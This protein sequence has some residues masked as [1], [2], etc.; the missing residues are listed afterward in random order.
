VA[1]SNGSRVRLIG[2]DTPECHYSRKL[3]RDSRRN[4]KDIATITKLGS[5]AREFT[6]SL[7]LGKAVSLE[8]DVER[9]DRYGGTLAYLYLDDGRFVNAEIVKAGYAQPMT[10]PPNVKHA[11]LFL[12]LEREARR[13][14]RGL[15][16]GPDM[17]MASGLDN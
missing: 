16:K 5:R 17:D 10:V 2:I 8:Y 14:G 6:K 7:C 13:E 11:D 15:W 9:R 12:N 1:L 4:G 3:L